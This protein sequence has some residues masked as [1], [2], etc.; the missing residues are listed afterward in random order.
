MQTI[1]VRTT[2]NV[3]IQ[4]PLA[5]VGDRIIAHLIDNLIVIA[6]V[7]PVMI[8]IINYGSLSWW[9]YVLILGVPVL[10][11]NL[12]FEIFMNGQ[13]P[14]KRAL[15]IRVIRLDGTEA[16]IGDF[17]LRWLFRLV[18]FQLLSPAVAIIAIAAGKKG[19]RIGDM[20][21]GTTVIKMNTASEVTAEEIFITTQDDYQ[22]TFLN[23][24]ELS[25][26]DIEIM[27]QALQVGKGGNLEP[28]EKVAEKIKTVLSID[29]QMPALQLLETL[30]KDFNHLTSMS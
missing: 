10:F 5:R 25:S 3:F 8:A 13:T 15:R 21:A 4:Y 17:I 24:V 2:Q 27:Q 9:V 22:P 6:Y 29:T 1:Q 30:I 14:G 12:F 16:T 23:V 19:Q 18:D 28:A 11:Y 20:V 26:R 7:L